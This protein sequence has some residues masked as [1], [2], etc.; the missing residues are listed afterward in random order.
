MNF[1]NPYSKFYKKHSIGKLKEITNQP[2][3]YQDEA[4][5]AAFLELEERKVEFLEEEKLKFDQ[6]K[7]IIEKSEKEKPQQKADKT[8]PELYSPTAI[9]GFSVFSILFGGILTMINLRKLQHKKQ[10]IIALLTSLILVF[11]VGL[12]TASNGMNPIISIAG[13]II[14]G[15]LLIE[16]F[17]K[18]LIPKEL[19]YRRKPTWIV[20]AILI[21]ITLLQYLIFKNNPEL[22]EQLYQKN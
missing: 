13:N 7:K 15:I 1:N 17:W 11:L 5:L 8:I 19:K 18:K 22:L 9:V 20:I 12:I 2:E 10:S 3:T 21:G 16:L 4:R 6:L 14:G